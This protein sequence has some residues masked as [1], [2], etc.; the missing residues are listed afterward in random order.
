MT[1]DRSYFERLY[2]DHQDPWE[3]RTRW[4]EARKR[5]LTMAA[6]PDERYLSVF[7][8]GCSIGLLTAELAERSDHVL[9]TDIS[10]QALEQARSAL[11]GHVELRRGA[12]PTDW[13]AGRFDLI[14]LSEV[15]YYL[16]LEDCHLLAELAI[17]TGRD[18][19]AVH[20]RHLVDDY[21][22]T[23]DEVH[24]VIGRCAD[25]GGLA[26][27]ASHLEADLRIEVWSTDHRSVA[28]RTGLRTA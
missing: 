11:P 23:G 2:R 17:T 6:L 10:A 26:M 25:R 22:L 8:P 4:Y 1:L 21:P 9:A 20:W 27:V 7:E 14:V 12:I 16:D 24:E 18:V 28:T 13:P 15:G 5:R 19:I 3:F